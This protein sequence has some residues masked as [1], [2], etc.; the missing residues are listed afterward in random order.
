[1]KINKYLIMEEDILLV[2]ILLQEKQCHISSIKINKYIYIFYS[3]EK[4]TKFHFLKIENKKIFKFN[5]KN[6]KQIN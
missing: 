3:T 1:M 2:L 6:N 4:K 5:F